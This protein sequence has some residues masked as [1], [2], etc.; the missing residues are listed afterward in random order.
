MLNENA[1][2]VRQKRVISM[3]ITAHSI[4]RDRYSRISIIFDISLLIASVFLNALVFVSD[5]F[6]VS[7]G[8]NPTNGKLF[9]GIISVILFA[10]A[11]V[12]ILLNT[13]QKSENHSQACTQ[14][15]YLLSEVRA[16]DEIIDETE[17]NTRISLFASKYSQITGI[18]IPI[19]DKKFNMVKSRHLRKVEFSKFISQHPN[20]NYVFQKYLFFKQS[21]KK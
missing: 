17:K 10:L 6:F 8:I 15:F 9:L 11:V 4:M 18:L 2:F 12:G 7:F 3:M 13:K 16:I 21:L 20:K 14:Y 1:E 5:D 19:P